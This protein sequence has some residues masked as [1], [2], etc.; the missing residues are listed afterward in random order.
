[1]RV[2]T[3]RFGTLTVTEDQ[4]F[5]FPMGLLGFARH[6]RFVILDHSDDS[7]FKWMQCVDDGDLAFIVTDPLFF[8]S[9]YHLEVRRSE[10]SVISPVSADELVVSVIMTVPSDPQE[11]SANLL[12]PLIFNMSN[13]MA[14]QYVLTDHRYPVRY[15]VM[16][17]ADSGGGL[18][19]PDQERPQRSISLR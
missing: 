3:A 7:P 1:M 15:F 5:V 13:R 12:A 17:E 14:M 11:M 10:L 19:A 8:R 4:V 9:D 16:R 18:P 2:E 6:K